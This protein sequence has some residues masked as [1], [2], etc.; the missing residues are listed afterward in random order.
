MPKILVCGL[1]S[2]HG[3][4]ENVIMNYYRN[5]NHESMKLDFICSGI[6]KIAY[7]SELKLYG[8]TI[9]YLPNKLKNPIRYRRE[10]NCFFKAKIKKYDY[11]WFNTSDL[12]DIDIL[13]LAKK[14]NVKNVIIHSHNS[15]LMSQGW[16]KII[17]YPI[18]LINKNRIVNYGT[19]FWACSLEASKWMFTKKN[20][21]NVKIIKNAIDISKTKFDASKREHIRRKYKLTNKFVIGNV[22]RINFQ[23]NQVF[24]L[25][26]I[27]KLI[28]DIPNLKLILVGEGKDKDI[29][30][31]QNKIK[32]YELENYVMLAG[33]Q[34]D[35]QSWY[36]AFD[37]FLF[38]SLFE[39]LSVSLL[40]AQSNGLPILASDNAAPNEVRINSNFHVKKL[41]DQI[42]DW[43]RE[44][45]QINDNNNR[46]NYKLI[47]YNFDKNNYNIKTAASKLEKLF[48]GVK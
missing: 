39:G 32:E 12:V 29:K 26:I 24:I 7:E 31:I 40:E 2:T 42:D 37:C 14:Y 21:K 20:Q 6:D 15:R 22:G 9:I 16:K 38:P 5:F 19:D 1:T 8:S 36:S 34:N 35:M 18:H 11:I 44:I 41:N 43:C 46:L 23:K 33:L 25:Q 30:F 13:V 27:K 4:I 47:Q 3:G 48:E 17:K 10:L 45:I 28:P